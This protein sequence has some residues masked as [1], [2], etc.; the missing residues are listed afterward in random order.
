[1]VVATKPPISPWCPGW[2]LC[3]SSSNFCD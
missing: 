2:F 1:M 3:V